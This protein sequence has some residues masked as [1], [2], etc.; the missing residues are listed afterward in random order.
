NSSVTEFKRRNGFTEVLVPRYFIPLTLKGRI[1]L[2]TGF[3]RGVAATLPEQLTNFL[4]DSRAF[5]YDKFGPKISGERVPS[6][7]QRTA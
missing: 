2:A 3:H 5:V 4:L 6:A 7:P 1:A